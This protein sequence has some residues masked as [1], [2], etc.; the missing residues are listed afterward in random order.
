MVK[1]ILFTISFAMLHL[2]GQCVKVLPFKSGQVSLA[3]GEQTN[4]SISIKTLDGTVATALIFKYA[5]GGVQAVVGHFDHLQLEKQ[6][7]DFKFIVSRLNMKYRGSNV[8]SRHL[9]V[10]APG[11]WARRD[12]ELAL[13]V[14]DYRITDFINNLSQ[15]VGV[16]PI[17]LPYSIYSLYHKDAFQVELSPV[18]VFYRSLADHGRVHMLDI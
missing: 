12:G 15:I 8:V 16:E 14:K 1:K 7:D 6:L 9:L 3:A 5:S 10:A 11:K 2:S 17:V 18:G 13:E 4:K